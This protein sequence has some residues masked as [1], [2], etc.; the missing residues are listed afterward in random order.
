MIE[1]N[2]TYRGWFTGGEQRGDLG[3][4]TFVAR[5]VQGAG[6]LGSLFAS[7][8]DGRLKMGDT[9]AVAYL[10]RGTPED[11]AS[12]SWGGRYVRAWSRQRL[13]IS[14]RPAR[15]SDVVEQ[16]GI[17][18]LLPSPRTAGGASAA[19]V[20]DGQEFP[21]SIDPAT[22]AA[23]FR[24]VPKDARRWSYRIES[25]DPSLRGHR[26]EFTSVRPAP[27][28][29]EEPDPRLPYWFTDDP[30]PEWSE[31]PHLGARTVSQWR[32]DFL[33][34]F[35]RRLDR[36]RGPAQATSSLRTNPIERE[37]PCPSCE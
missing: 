31:G 30:S 13:V 36:C 12:P 24:F 15:A 6:A 21:A 22:G 14:D 5:H 35:A 3:N 28:R 11:P 2:A 19:L 29:A 7:L 37:S 23:R 4:E 9:P 26:G 25:T 33:R 1:S 17:V 16:F 27:R 18:E 10:L 20:V 34:D 32:G 8:L